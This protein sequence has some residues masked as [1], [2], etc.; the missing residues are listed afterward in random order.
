MRIKKIIG[1]SNDLLISKIWFFEKI[2]E[3]DKPIARITKNKRERVQINK[4]RNGWRE[5]TTGTTEIQKIIKDYYKQQTRQPRGNKFLEKY[6]L[7]RLNSEDGENLNK[8]ITNK[9][10]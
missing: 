3:I 10:I 5:V 1:K 7:P 8:P 6:N 4:I 9:E 2:N